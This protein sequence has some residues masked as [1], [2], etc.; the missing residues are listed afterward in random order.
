MKEM[1]KLQP[2]IAELREKYKNDKTK[3]SQE[4]MALYKTHKVNPLGGCLPM[5]IQ[6]PVFFG[7]YKA[8]MYSIELRHAP[9]LLVDTGSIG[10]RS[11]LHY[12]HYHGGNHAHSAE[13][14]PRNG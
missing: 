9:F 7:L 14:D 8:L 6:I 12:A 11:L 2:K 3:L 5:V 10:K 4:T 1:Q 13:D